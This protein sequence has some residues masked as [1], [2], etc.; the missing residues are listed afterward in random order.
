MLTKITCGLTLGLRKKCFDSE[1]TVLIFSFYLINIF[2]SVILRRGNKPINNNQLMI[3]DFI[4]FC[5]IW[6]FNFQNIEEKW[7]NF[8]FYN[9][10]GTLNPMIFLLLNLMITHDVKMPT[11]L[12]I[13]LVE[14]KGKKLFLRRSYYAHLFFL[15]YKYI[16]IDHFKKKI[17][18]LF[19]NFTGKPKRLFF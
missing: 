15:S 11:K 3:T 10:S 12:L 16:Y 2:M 1:V 18:S 13:I 17:T 9:I 19:S 7:K 5:I 8:S 14:A 6:I 4:D